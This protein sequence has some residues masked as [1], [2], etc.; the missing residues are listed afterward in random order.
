[1][2]ARERAKGNGKEENFKYWVP[3]WYSVLPIRDN[4]DSMTAY[5]FYMTH[6]SNT[7]NIIMKG[8]TK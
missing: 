2:K 4:T 1:M 3:A 6:A 7:H 5:Y 8:E